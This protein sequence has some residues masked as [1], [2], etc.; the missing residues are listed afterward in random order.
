MPAAQSDPFVIKVGRKQNDLVYI[1]AVLW[2]LIDV[3]NYD[4]LRTPLSLCS[5]R[6]IEEVGT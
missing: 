4:F 5:R 6:S 1:Y 2:V 3:K